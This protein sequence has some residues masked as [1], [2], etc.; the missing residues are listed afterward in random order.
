MNV[1]RLSERV[2][3]QP[4]AALSL[5]A[6]VGA[7]YLCLAN[8]NYV[9]LWH[10]EAVVSSISK[11]L[12][13]QGDIV[14]WDGRNLVG[15]P[16]GKSLNEDLRDVAPPVQYLLTAAGLAIFGFN[17][18]GARVLHALVGVLALGF[19]YLV[20][21]QQLPNNP[22]LT[23]LIFLFAAWSAQLLLYFRQARYYSAVVL[24]MMA[25]FYLYERYWQTKSPLH[26]AALTGVAVL[27]FFN[28]YT[29]GT[30][31]MLA[32]AAWHL[33]FRARAT[34]KREWL[35]FAACGMVVAAL[36]LAYLVF[37]GLIGGDRDPSEGFLTVDVGEAPGV[38]PLL[39]LKIWI[40][41][42]DLFTADWISWPVF[43][44]FS[45]MAFLALSGTGVT[46][47]SLQDGK[48]GLPKR[49][50]PARSKRAARRQRGQPVPALA[51]AT[52]D[53][54]P[55]AA[56]SK[57][58]LLGGLCAL[59]SALLSVQPV[60][61]TNVQLDLRYFIAAL[62]LLLV[63]KGLFA[64]WLW[65]KS[66]IAGV[67]VVAVLIFTSAGAAP[68][69]MRSDWTRERTLGFHLF[70]LVREIHQPYPTSTAMVSDYLLQHAEQDD[71]V[72]G[73][74]FFASREELTWYTG[75]LVHFCDV[76]G[77]DS[78]VPREKIESWGLPI[79]IGKCAPDWIVLYGGLPQED[80]DRIMVQYELAV[81]LDVFPGTTQRPQLN[82]H[83]FEPIPATRGN[84]G[85]LR[86]RD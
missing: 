71:L 30:A 86:Q 80:M 76:L 8:L 24:C 61:W 64:E 13:E 22:R 62:P 26:L 47:R 78:P 15:G 85:I 35:A 43:I 9:T 53:D 60:W 65:R 68:I 16:N 40:C 73:P 48:A 52:G 57:L 17:E 63:M 3:A 36:G 74:R 69:N 12:L 46:G 5:C 67:A 29:S 33:L 34:M 50:R 31:A 55:L 7:A 25:G 66:R 77:P 51:Q 56:V 83:M 59:F 2:C 10:D 27:A 1:K 72:S 82:H 6:F 75:H 58:L 81:K 18:I 11:N 4:Y 23:F 44:W 37:I 70:Q 41:V 79:Y 14:G 32:L 38:L 28:H 39:F 19:F 84:V 49:S 42:R 21:R 20:L 45:A 54:L